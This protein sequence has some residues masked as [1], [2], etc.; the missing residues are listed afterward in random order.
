MIASSR[1]SGAARL[2]LGG[3]ALAGQIA[4]FVVLTLVGF[5]LA[6]V[7]MVFPALA[8]S[9]LVVV[10]YM[11]LVFVLPVLGAWLS[12]RAHTGQAG[13]LAVALASL[14][15]AACVFVWTSR[16]A[17][18]GD[19]RHAVR[20][21]AV[22]WLVILPLAS[23]LGGFLGSYIRRGRPQSIAVGAVLVLGVGWVL[24]GIA[25]VKPRKPPAPMVTDARDAA[26]IEQLR[27][28]GSNVA[29]PHTPEFFLYFPTEK[30]AREAARQLEVEGYSAK[31]QLGAGNDGQWLCLATT[32]LVPSPEA[33]AII[34]RRME[35]LAASL[36]GEYDG[37]GSPIVP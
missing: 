15:G 35:G 25:S 27:K 5:G 2:E 24:L 32:T 11:I 33:L 9:R 31:A 8:S 13:A 3:L 22:P 37:W 12:V 16:S 34:R 21:M 28:A 17:G 20:F 23:V 30:A 7:G 36:D 14:V 4:G 1:P 26:L 18:F 19:P 29:K 10:L 6:A